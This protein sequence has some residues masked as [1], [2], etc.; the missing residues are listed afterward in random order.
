M[1]SEKRHIHLRPRLEAA[2][3]M[4]KGCAVA[5]DVGCD[6]GR[7][8]CALVQRGICRRVIA[9]DIS[10]ASAKKAHELSRLCGLSDSIEIR[11]SSGL[12]LLKPGDVDGVVLAGMGGELI[13]E[14]LKQNLPVAHSLSRIVMQ[15]MRGIEE[16]RQFLR[17]GG[18]HILCD[19]IV[20][21]AGRYYQVISAAYK[22]R[23]E[24]VM[25]GFPDDVY[26]IGQKPFQTHE[27]LLEPLL[28]QLDKN[29]RRRIAD[30]EAG[31]HVPDVLYEKL[32]KI[33]TLFK[34][35]EENNREAEGLS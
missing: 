16:L 1:L 15:P 17:E 24:P 5:A 2:A 4:L 10:E 21:D 30:A 11:I 23:P 19:R 8:S 25:C 14:L 28:K 7:L 29:C 18:F 35:L 27:P 31:G 34:L 32:K 33:N 12:D 3:E 26:F 20:F 9:S 13:A 6:H 22:G